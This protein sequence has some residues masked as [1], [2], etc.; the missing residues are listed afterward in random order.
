MSEPL[1]S[2]MDALVE[3]LY[4][5]VKDIANRERYAIYGHS[6]GGLAAYLL[7]LKL[8]ENDHRKPEHVFITGTTAP[9]STSRTEK[10]RSLLPKQEFI[11][12]VKELGG[13]PDEILESEDMLNFL[14]PILRNDFGASERYLYEEGAVLDIPITVITGSEEDMEKEDI[15]LWQQES[16]LP[17]D[18]RQLPGGHFFIMEHANKLVEIISKKLANN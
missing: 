18:F 8:L 7:T 12:E 14:E 1:I 17:V 13:M 4:R 10:K 11:Q 15:L 16:C 3:D 9:S 5:Q 6:L 2:E